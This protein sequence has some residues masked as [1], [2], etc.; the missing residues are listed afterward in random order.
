[1]NS[2]LRL[3]MDGFGHVL[4]ST[5]TE[6]VAYTYT[7]KS[8]V[9]AFMQKERWHEVWWRSRAYYNI[10]DFLILCH[11]STN[12]F[13]FNNLLFFYVVEQERV[14]NPRNFPIYLLTQLND[15]FN[16]YFMCI[17]ICRRRI[18]GNKISTTGF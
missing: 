17:T 4:R 18:I 11:D 6:H 14:Q 1:M 7:S 10:R 12:K 9:R 5:I 2:E 13:D 3:F 15:I 8:S 16:M